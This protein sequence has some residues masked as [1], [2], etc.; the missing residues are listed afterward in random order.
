MIEGLNFISDLLR[1]YKHKESVYLQDPREP[2]SLDF[3]TAIQELYV[4]IFEYQVR[5]ICFLARKWS[6][7]GAYQTMQLG[8]W[9]LMLKQVKDSDEKCHKYCVALNE[10]KVRLLYNDDS[11][12]ME[13]SID[14]RRD[15]FDMFEAS[16][17][18]RQKECRDDEETAVLKRGLLESLASDYKSDKNSIPVKVPDTCKWF[19]EDERFLNWRSHKRLSVLWVSAGPG[20]GKSVLSRALID[21]ERVSNNVMTSSVC[22]FFF[23]DGQERRTRGT[24]ALSA[25]LH[26]LFK[27]TNLISHALPSY[28]ENGKTLRDNISELWDVLLKSAKDPE[29]GQ[30]ICILDA[31]DECEEKTRNILINN[32]IGFASQKGLHEQSS[33]S[34]KFLVTS[35]PYDNIEEQFQSLSDTST[36]LRFDGDEKS[37]QIGQ[38]INLVIDV[39]VKNITSGFSDEDRQLISDS[40]KMKNN[41]TYL[42]LYLN[43]DIIKSSRSKYRKTSSIKE[44]LSDLPSKVSDAYGRILAKSPDKRLARTLLQIIVAATRPLS[45][46]EANIALA[47]AQQGCC[48][49][50]Q[51]LDL[52]PLQN[53]KS[54]VQ[55]ICGLF[56]SIHGGKLSLI[57]QTARE[58]LIQD[59]GLIDIDPNE[60]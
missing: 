52:W 40:L 42:W 18:Q 4:N 50:H 53:F 12:C 49:S 19:I 32:L 15:I 28:Q 34:L 26:Q 27:N 54:L 47:L 36:Y 51:A 31:L 35:R 20:C 10:E 8:H 45:L 5:L 23:K 43:I 37:Q 57:H 30:I 17:T 38:E 39:E 7:L 13:Q 59:T 14:I 9:K 22:Y 25:I 48:M 60:W 16:R 41:R 44:L 6:K 1:L 2:A 33:F 21:E 29:A 3:V 11:S 55:N 46:V 58:Y 56:V 24:H